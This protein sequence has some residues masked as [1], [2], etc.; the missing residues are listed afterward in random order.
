VD[1]DI[2]LLRCA[3]ECKRVPLPERDFGA[4]EEDVL[5]SQ[6]TA[7]ILLNLNLDDLGRV[8]NDSGDD[9]LLL[10]TPFTSDTLQQVNKATRNPVLPERGNIFA[11]RGAIGGEKTEGSV[12]GKEE[13]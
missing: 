5:S 4:A 1:T 10:G 8:E 12:E 3:G 13:E 6:S 2:V 9:S 11:I 7:V